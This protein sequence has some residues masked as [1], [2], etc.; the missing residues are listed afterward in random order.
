MDYPRRHGA[1]A[2]AEEAMEV[3]DKPARARQQQQPQ[4]SQVGGW[5]AVSVFAFGVAIWYFVWPYLH[6]HH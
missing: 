1:G 3:R 5:V 4:H 6:L 2:E